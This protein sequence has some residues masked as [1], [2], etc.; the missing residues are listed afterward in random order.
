MR[1]L[2]SHRTQSS[3]GQFVHIRALTEALTDLGHEVLI[4][5]PN[6]IQHPADLA[7]TQLDAHKRAKSGV[8][9]H[10]PQPLYELAEY[11]YSAPAWLRLQKAARKFKPDILYERANLFYNAGRWLKGRVG[12]PLLLEVNAPLAEERTTHG[13]LSLQKLAQTQEKNLWLSADHLLP[14]SSPLADRL[15]QAGVPQD[16]ITIIPNGVSTT[17]LKPGNGR[18]VRARYGLEGAFIIG[19]TGFVRDWHGAEMALAW[20]ATPAGQNAHFLLV[21]DGPATQKSR[22][23]AQQLKVDARFHITGII[24]REA[25]NDHIAVFDVALQPR[26]TPYASPLKL[27]DY[28]AQSKPIIAPDQANIRDILTQNQN[29]LLFNPESQEDFFHQ[30]NKCVQDEIFVQQLGHQARHTLEENNYTWPA[31]AERVC[32]IA[33]RLCAHHQ[34]SKHD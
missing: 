12:L 5:G 16:K 26:V 31:N 20:L 28:M 17:Q 18:A 4:C 33:A 3:D 21:G 6:A 23:Q 2:Y 1:I 30:L 34:K 32:E 7:E 10:I 15:Q 29:A 24:Q 27:F 13:G 25:L 9:D 8:M 11:A 22:Q 14:V 19:F